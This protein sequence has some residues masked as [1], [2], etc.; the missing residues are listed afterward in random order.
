MNPCCTHTTAC[1][2]P[3]CA[4]RALPEQFDDPAHY[5]T[6]C[7]ALAD[8]GFECRVSEPTAS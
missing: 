7:S 1:R 6:A 8:A 2:E 3:P 4:L 5:Q